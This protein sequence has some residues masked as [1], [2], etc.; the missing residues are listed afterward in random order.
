MSWLDHYPRSYYKKYKPLSVEHHA[1]WFD[2]YELD[3]GVKVIVEAKHS[4]EV[5]A[6]LIPGRDRAVLFDTGLGFY[7]IK[8]VVEELYKGEIVVVNSHAHFDHIGGNQLFPKVLAFDDDFSRYTAS[9]GTPT[10]VY[11]NMLEEE[12][13]AEGRPAHIDPKTFSLPPYQFEP[14]ADG[15]SIDLGDRSLEVIHTPGHSSDSIM[16]LD[17]KNRLLFT[18]DTLYAAALYAHFQAE[19]FGGSDVEDYLK[20]LEKIQGRLA[21]VDA[22]YVAHND[23]ILPPDFANR[24]LAALRLA[25]EGQ[26]GDSHPVGARHIY[27]EE[28]KEVVTY[29]FD[30]FSIQ[31]RGQR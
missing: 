19:A 9:R 15:D 30:G 12:M 1:G 25:K 5:N 10:S 8:K 24:V 4:E 14:L 16:L 23:P 6:Y 3:K 17:G 22:L 29:F 28:G 18:G 21:E 13:F 27:L 11:G 31:L 2:V 20:S 7:D 26:A